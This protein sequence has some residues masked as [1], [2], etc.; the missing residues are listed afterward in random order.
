MTTPA[1]ASG[2]VITYLLTDVV[3]S[4]SLWDAEPETMATALARH[5]EVIEGAATES[6]GVVLHARGEGDSRFLVF[7]DARDAATVAIAVVRDLQAERWPTFRP[8]QV[9][10]ALHT[11]PN[12]GEHYGPELNW[13]VRLRGAAH[14]DEILLSATTAQALAGWVPPGGH[15]ADLGGQRLLDAGLS[16]QVAQL[17]HPEITPESGL[18]VPRLSRRHN[19]PEST[20]AFVGRDREL[21]EL[22]GLIAEMRLVTLTG[23]G[24]SGKT[25]LALALAADVGTDALDG[26]WFVE[27]APLSDPSLVPQAVAAAIGV[28]ETPGQPL[29]QTLAAT[30]GTRAVLLLLDNCEHLRAAAAG[31]AR[32]LLEACSGLRVL[33]TSREPLGVPGETVWN[34]PPLATPPSTETEPDEVGAYPAVALFVARANAATPDFALT[35]ETCV[36]VGELCRRLDGIPLALELAAARLGQD[37]L[38]TVTTSLRES[39]RHIGQSGS[40]SRHQTL[41]ATLSWS[42]ELLTPPERALFRRLAVFAGGADT[43]AAE[44]VGAGA[45][46][47]VDEV[48][49]VLAA[50]VDKSL[51]AALPQGEVTRY[52]MLETVR[53]YARGRLEEAGE[54]G[55]I[56]SCHLDWML[57]VAEAAEPGL[58]GAP[59]FRASLQRML[60]EQDNLRAALEW[61]QTAAWPVAGLQLVASA[62]VFWWAAGSLREGKA[63]VDAALGVQQL[64]DPRLRAKLLHEGGQFALGATEYQTAVARLEESV[65]W[66]RRVGDPHI[67]ARALSALAWALDEMGNWAA[68]RT[69]WE[70]G[71]AVAR[72]AGDDITAAQILHNMGYTASAAGDLSGG[73]H[74]LSEALDLAR[75][76]GNDWQ[77]AYTLSDLGVTVAAR[78]DVARGLSLCEEALSLA[79]H[80]GDAVALQASLGSVAELSAGRGDSRR[81]RALWREALALASQSG[82]DLQVLE[83][84]EGL[85]QMAAT[86]DADVAVRLLAAVEAWRRSAGIPRPA[87][88][89]ELFERAVEAARAALGPSEFERAWASGM[90]ISQEEAVRLA[91]RG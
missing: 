57:S 75:A 2:E 18:D 85:G 69:V 39:L 60:E 3:G 62:G 91:Q 36:P 38:A 73:E 35:A 5:D 24:G 58:E 34:V 72:R 43:D 63:W 53:E 13:A 54:S 15:L 9:R 10:V 82:N 8:L 90:E 23:T 87:L 49:D 88:R 46:V 19:L 56:H 14:P 41:E 44:T 7:P 48:W 80:V 4:T 31:T 81:A 33:A 45:P 77:L 89:V 83:C 74:L 70:E 28:R 40:E 50:L 42:H 47:Q 86:A 22:R 1:S 79:R 20:T 11:V 59:E 52:R 12:T 55:A 32:S 68:A 66:A 16:E 30:L 71:L 51:V 76:R 84:I 64:G 78:G 21:T 26:V 61:S 27:L 6:G 17:C 25:R 67:E 37:S 65:A 29:L